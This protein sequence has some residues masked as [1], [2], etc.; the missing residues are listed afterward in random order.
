MSQR[1]DAGMSRMLGEEALL[2]S[3]GWYQV[4]VVNGDSFAIIYLRD[5]NTSSMVHS[6]TQE[7]CS[8]DD[9]TY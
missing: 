8:N 7:R 5:S 1:A 9:F 3:I 4:C 6:S 2:C